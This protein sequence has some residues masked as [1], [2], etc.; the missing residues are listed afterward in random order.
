MRIVIG[1]VPKGN[2]RDHNIVRVSSFASK[3]LSW[4]ERRCIVL[5]VLVGCSL[6]R[7]SSLPF[8]L[9]AIDPL[10]SSMIS[11][12]NSSLR[13]VVLRI[14]ILQSLHKAVYQAVHQAVHTRYIHSVPYTFGSHV[15]C[16]I[17]QSRAR[18]SKRH[19]PFFPEPGSTSPHVTIIDLNKAS[20]S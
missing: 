13:I 6:N 15:T 5:V 19:V 10:L 16:L 12:K 7:D 8:F 11:T 20:K 1:R 18:K 2:R 14:G 3:E 4:H 9:R 17:S